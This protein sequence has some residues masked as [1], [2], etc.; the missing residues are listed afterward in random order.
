MAAGDLPAVT[1]LSLDVHP[2]YPERP[3]VLAEKFRLFPSGCFALES[4]GTVAGYCFSHPWIAGAPPA[5][6]TFLTALPGKPTHY[7]IHDLTLAASMRRRGFAEALMPDLLRAARGAA[8]DRMALVAVSGS[9][10]FWSRMGFQATPD[11]AIQS[12]ARAKYDDGAVHM[13]RSLG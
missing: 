4:E 12:A 3:E 10:P 9:S 5:L 13:E 2:N 1:T 8:L 11:E 6:D 7:F